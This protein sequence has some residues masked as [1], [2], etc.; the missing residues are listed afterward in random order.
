MTELEIARYK[1]AVAI[2]QLQAFGPDLVA[3]EAAGFVGAALKAA[4]DAV[5]AIDA[6]KR[7]ETAAA[8]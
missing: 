5:V 7:L 3:I 8:Q 4:Q 2:A 1:M 6:V